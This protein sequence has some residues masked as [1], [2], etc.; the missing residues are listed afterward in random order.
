MNNLSCLSKVSNIVFYFY[1]ILQ[2]EKW[3]TFART[4][5]PER[6]VRNKTGDLVDS[7]V[8]TQIS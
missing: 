3:N 6:A 7:Q 2:Y 5:F 1:I 8:I 4:L